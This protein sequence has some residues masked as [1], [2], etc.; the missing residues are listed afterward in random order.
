MRDLRRLTLR[1]AIGTLDRRGPR[2]RTDSGSVMTYLLRAIV[3]LMLILGAFS[4]VHAESAIVRDLPPGLQIPDAARGGPA[5][6]VDRATDAYLGLLSPEQRALSDQYFEGGYWLQLWE[7]LYGLVIAGILL[8]SGLSRRMRDFA[9][10]ITRQRW[11]Q[12]LIYALPWLLAG[13]LLSLPLDIYQ[14]YLREHQYGLATQTFGDWFVDALKG[15][16]V[17]LVVVPPVLALLYAAVR[18]AG[19]RWWVW[20][21][22]GGFVLLLFMMMLA[23]VFVDP[24][25]NDYKPLREGAVREAILSL[26]RA[27]QIPTDNVVE[28][29]ASRQTT[30]ISANVAGFL[31]TTRVALN[32]NLLDKTSAPEI[33]AVMGHEMGHYVLNHGLRLTLYLSLVLLLGFYVVHRV[34]D[35]ALARW[36]R[37]WGLRDRSDPAALPLAV[38]I[39]GLFFLLITPLV[40]SIIRQAEAE[41]DAFGLNAAQEPNG[42]AMA[43]MRLSTYRKLRPGPLEE[44]FF[45][46]HPSGYQ[47]VHASMIWLK[48]HP[49]NPTSHAPSAAK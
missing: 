1:T 45:Y 26:A 24:L 18:R 46:D 30:R 40:N 32:D 41:A 37:R 10:R 33:K 15:L 28:F 47:R 17:S 42:F 23:P 39:L 8:F 48:E 49:D 13:F 25:F 44:V 20:A 38:A 21:G 7:P 11:L 43:A 4:L 9:E 36:G 3:A 31:G 12:P 16:A 19:T 35:V 34:F 2:A 5:F 14:G 29:D 6:D 27:N 22:G